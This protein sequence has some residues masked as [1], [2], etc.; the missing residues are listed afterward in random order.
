[1]EHLRP[2]HKIVGQ[3]DADDA[4]KKGEQG[5]GFTQDIPKPA[6]PPTREALAKF[7][8]MKWPA[9]YVPN[10]RLEACC[11]KLADAILAAFPGLPLR[12]A[13]SREEWRQWFSTQFEGWTA[14]ERHSDV[15]ADRILAK[16]AEL[17]QPMDKPAVS[18]I[19]SVQEIRDLLVGNIVWGQTVGETGQ[20][21]AEQLHALIASQLV[22]V[23]QAGTLDEDELA[24]ILLEAYDANINSHGS[25][26]WPRAEA[27]AAIALFRGKSVKPVVSS[28][29]TVEEM[30]LVAY[31]AEQM[32]EDRSQMWAGI[33]AIHAMLVSRLTEKKNEA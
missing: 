23:P 18:A 4:E 8:G 20:V 22:E 17:S 30:Y 31:K 33:R 3:L 12:R 24:R 14:V 6:D 1:M 16:L 29:P 32:P 21:S 25:G 26:S 5:M 28:I 7:I 13:M 9:P 27:R 2:L 19:P 15:L 10:A 11:H